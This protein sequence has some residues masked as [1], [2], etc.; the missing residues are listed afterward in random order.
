MKKP[1]LSRA[2]IRSLD[3]FAACTGQLINQSKCS[4]LFSVACPQGTQDT[5]RTILQVE[6]DQFEAKYLGL[7]T[8]DGRMNRGKFES[9]QSRLSKRLIEWGDGLLAQSAR[10]ILIKAIAQ[11]IPTYVMGVFKLPFSVCDDLTKLIR[12]YWWGAERGKR[13]THWVSWAKLNRA[14]S[15]G[16]MGFRDM[17]LFNQALLARQA[18]R[19]LA[20]PNSLC[21]RVLKARYFPNGNLVDTVF[22]WKSILNLD[23]HL[24]W[25]ETSEKRIDLESGKWS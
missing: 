6:R 1:R 14:K 7:P 25:S 8:P 5:I 12:N 24:I 11:A 17:R 16:G 3:I 13:R 10:E 22:Y 20:F 15:N 9:L 18:W 4:I 23:S 2:Q 21:A 19:L